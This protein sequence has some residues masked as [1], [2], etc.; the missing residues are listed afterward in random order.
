MTNFRF[1]AS[2]VAVTAGSLTLC[3]DEIVLRDGRRLDGTFIGG[4]ARLVEFL[5]S[6]GKTMKLNLEDVVALNFSAPPK[7]PAAAPAPQKPASRPTILIRAGVTFKI[8]TI[9]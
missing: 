5:P 2:I 3:A 6:S 8:R 9:D 7:A 1:L 4:T